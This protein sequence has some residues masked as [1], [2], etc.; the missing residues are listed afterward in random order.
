MPTGLRV[1]TKPD[2]AAKRLWGARN[3]EKIPPHVSALILLRW[4][5][6]EGGNR[7]AVLGRIAETWAE[8]QRDGLVTEAPVAFQTLETEAKSFE[9]ILR[10][11]LGG[12]AMVAATTAR[13]ADLR[14]QNIG[15]TTPIR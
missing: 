7:D 9:E 14:R 8:L 10:S 5:A 6:R 15:D 1:K 12:E 4:S 2:A 11:G 3:Y 13:I